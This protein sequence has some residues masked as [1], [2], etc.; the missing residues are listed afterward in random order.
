MPRARPS[1]RRLARTEVRDRRVGVGSLVPLWAPSRAARRAA[2][3]DHGPHTPPASRWGS[4]CP[5]WAPC[6]G[7]TP[8][9]AETFFSCCSLCHK[10]DFPP[11]LLTGPVSGEKKN[12]RKQTSGWKNA[13]HP[14]LTEC[15][16]IM[17]I[18]SYQLFNRNNGIGGKHSPHSA[19]QLRVTLQR[20]AVDIPPDRRHAHSARSGPWL[21]VFFF[22]FRVQMTPLCSVG[23]PRVI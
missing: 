5:K 7:T 18:S 10:S 15:K 21:A 8:R 9:S 1:L 12:T 6:L 17:F 16:L 19:S 23:K 3:W 4:C 20:L 2:R 22:F 11:M 14:A 13:P